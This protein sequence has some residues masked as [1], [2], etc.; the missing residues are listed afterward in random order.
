MQ[1][2]STLKSGKIF[3]GIKRNQIT[4]KFGKGIKQLGEKKK[5]FQRAVGGWKKKQPDLWS[6]F[7]DQLYSCHS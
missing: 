4:K 3:E 7:I 1:I 5:I 2:L 6:P